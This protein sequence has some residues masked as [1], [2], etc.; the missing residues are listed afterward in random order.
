VN[1][2]FADA[3]VDVVVIGFGILHFSDRDRALRE[4]FRVLRSSARCGLSVR[5]GLDKV[6]RLGIVL[7]TVEKNGRTDEKLPPGPPHFRCGNVAECSNALAAARFA[8][9]ELARGG[10]NVAPAVS[11]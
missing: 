5:T 9:I 2:P 1:L 8:D 10:A 6:A 3:R 4:A 11:R 7:R